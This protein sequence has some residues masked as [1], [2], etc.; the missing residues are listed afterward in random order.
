MGLPVVR[1]RQH[2]RECGHV[3]SVLG[4]PWWRL[5]RQGAVFEPLPRDAAEDVHL[6]PPLQVLV[7]AGPAEGQHV[8]PVPDAAHDRLARGA[9]AVGLQAVPLRRAV[10]GRGPR[11]RPAGTAVRRG[12]RAREFDVGRVVEAVVAE[13]APVRR[14]PVGPAEAVGEVCRDGVVHVAMDVHQR[15]R[16]LRRMPEAKEG[17]AGNGKARSEPA[18]ELRQHAVGHHPA[19]GHASHVHAPPIH[20]ERVFDV[21]EQGLEEE[22]V[23]HAGAAGALVAAALRRQAAWS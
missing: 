23:V 6:V 7:D 13:D 14:L 9:G 19:D 2:L 4:A 15:D 1:H 12:D 16:M 3:H 21:V 20:A 8:V 11:Q 17:G 10:L 5:L 22:R 18:R